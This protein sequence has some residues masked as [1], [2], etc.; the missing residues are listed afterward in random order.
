[1]NST[2]DNFVTWRGEDGQ[3]CMSVNDRERAA[4]ILVAATPPLTLTERRRK[5]SAAIAAADRWLQLAKK[6][7]KRRDYRASADSAKG[8]VRA[9]EKAMLYEELSDAT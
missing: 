4:A 6:D 3:A 8:A 1:M 2:V 7:C 9:L 5:W